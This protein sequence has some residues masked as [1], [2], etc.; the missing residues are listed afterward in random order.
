MGAPPAGTARTG[1]P[2]S[3]VNRLGP[4]T[5]R[6]TAAPSHSTPPALGGAV[7]HQ[8]TGQP[9][10][11]AAESHDVRDGSVSGGGPHIRQLDDFVPVA[12]CHPATPRS[13]GGENAGRA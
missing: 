5:R 1:Q 3:P 4:A 12:Q 11:R 7:T 10:C 9:G 13:P 6:D 2:P 8:L